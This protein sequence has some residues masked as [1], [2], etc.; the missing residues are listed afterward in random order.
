MHGLR[1]GSLGECFVLRGLLGT[2]GVLEMVGV[3][4]MAGQWSLLARRWWA[5]QLMRW[6]ICAWL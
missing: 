4:W 3:L 2:L 6:R 5:A 1:C